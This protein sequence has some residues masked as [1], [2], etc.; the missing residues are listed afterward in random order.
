MYNYHYLCPI[1]AV[2][3]ATSGAVLT[4]EADGSQSREQPP[5]TTTHRDAHGTVTATTTDP[6]GNRDEAA[7]IHNTHTIDTISQTSSTTQTEGHQEKDSHHYRS[8]PDHTLSP[9]PPPLSPPPPP[10]GS[11]G[12]LHTSML[13]L[14][15]SD[16]KP[17]TTAASRPADETPGS[18]CNK[19]APL[20]TLQP[21]STR[22]QSDL[23]PPVYLQSHAA[24]SKLEQEKLEATE[25]RSSGMNGV[26]ESI[27]ARGGGGL[28]VRTKPT[29]SW[30]FGTRESFPTKAGKMGRLEWRVN[31]FYSGLHKS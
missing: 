9:P 31:Y 29:A 1:V 15:L 14:S 21:H 26:K 19:Q 11:C 22:L 18:F 3:I 16:K 6:E 8:S 2:A 25:L 7:V 10:N 30:S 23:H 12:P 27:I 17:P 13:G 28:N 4:S 20:K 24:N 5:A